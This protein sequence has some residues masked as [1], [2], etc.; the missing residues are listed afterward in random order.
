MEPPC[1]DRVA[2]SLMQSLGRDPTHKCKLTFC[3]PSW[4]TYPYYE[5]EEGGANVSSLLPILLDR[6]RRTGRSSLRKR[7]RPP[8]ENAGGG[9][10]VCVN[11]N[12]H[13]TGTPICVCSR[14][15]LP[16]GD[17]TLRTSLVERRLT[18]I[19]WIIVCYVIL[20][21]VLLFAC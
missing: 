16:S 12:A 18:S 15:I 17:F 9:V 8:H 5:I 10:L 14:M 21:A 3:R 19:H 6:R 1:N 7:E 2:S 11:G 13:D 20:F 4:L